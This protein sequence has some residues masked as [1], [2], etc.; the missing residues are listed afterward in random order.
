MEEALNCALEGITTLLKRDLEYECDC[1]GGEEEVEVRAGEL[2][3]CVPIQ[4]S[5]VDISVYM[6]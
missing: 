4:S 1:E 2:S 5:G 6:N 3:E